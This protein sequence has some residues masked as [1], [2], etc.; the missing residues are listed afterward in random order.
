MRREYL[1][2]CKSSLI[3]FLFLYAYL[4]PTIPMVS[5]SRPLPWIPVDGDNVRAYRVSYGK[6]LGGTHDE[7]MKR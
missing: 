4:S 7:S 2:R 3:Y 1:E 5:K 6:N